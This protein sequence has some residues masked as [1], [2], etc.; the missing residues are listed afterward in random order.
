MKVLVNS[1][2]AMRALRANALRSVLTT[3]GIIFGVAAVVI[4]VAIG[5]GTQQRIQEEIERLGTSTLN[6]M[7]SFA[8]VGGVRMGAGTWFRITDDDARALAS[9]VQH[10]IVAPIVRGRAHAVVA[11][12]NWSTT[13]WGATEDFFAAREWGLAGG[14][15]FVP[16]E[17]DMGRKVVVLGR[18]VAEKLFPDGGDPVDQT[19]RINHLN[20][21]IVGVLE[22]KG[23]MIDGADMDDFVVTPLITARNHVLG[24]VAGSSRAVNSIIVKVQDDVQLEP[25]QAEIRQ[26]LRQRHRLREDQDDTFRI[27]NMSEFLRMQEASSSALTML[28][29]AVASISLLVGG[30]GIMNIML[31]S[32]TERT[33]EI[34]IRA[35][36]GATPRDLMSQFLTEAVLLSLIGAGIGA[37]LGVAGTFVAEQ[38]FAMRTALTIEPLLLAS[39]FAAT[40]GIV[41]G[42]Y[43]AWKAS[44][45]APIEALRYD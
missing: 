41:F 40:V 32:V 33:R 15:T 26:V 11:N 14:R 13:I 18:T 23:Q 2:E 36:V 28:L 5:A 37:L 45:L 29:A 25:V 6:I 12:A 30:I 35:A 24:R 19:I 21:R 27:Q 9:E 39:G 7:P 4:M 17:V 3:L 10:V 22:P 43:P 34:G 8:R 1:R 20:F 38:Y 44:R 16:E 31:V 42:F